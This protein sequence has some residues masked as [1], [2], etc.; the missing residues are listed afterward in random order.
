MSV[1]EIISIIVSCLAAGGSLVAIFT[2]H[3]AKKQEI[4]KSGEDHDS[5]RADIKYMRNTLDDL[6]VDMRELMRKQD[7]QTER[8]TRL[9]ES[10]KQAHKRIDTLEKRINGQ[11][12][13]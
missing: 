11:Q 10:A 9:E 3:N 5:V 2:Y 13:D 1:G 4:Y 6:R 7:E 12:E 8:I